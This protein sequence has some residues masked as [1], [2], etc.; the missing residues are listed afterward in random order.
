[1]PSA[2][3]SRSLARIAGLLA[4]GFLALLLLLA[5]LVDSDA[6][7]RRVTDV[8]LPRA[9]ALLGRTVTL[10][11]ARLSLFPLPAVEM[12][13]L[14]IEGLTPDRPLLSAGLAQ[15]RLAWWPLLRSFG[16][17]VEVSAVELDEVMLNTIR[18][19]DGS[20]AHDPVLARLNE[21]WAGDSSIAVTV[22]RF[23]LRDGVVRVLDRS[24]PGGVGQVALSD[25]DFT[26]TGLTP[27]D[28]ARLEW[29]AALQSAEQNVS[30]ELRIEPFPA[31][32]GELGPGEWPQVRGRLAVNGVPIESVDE[33]LPPAVA[34]TIS[35]G[36]VRLESRLRTDDDGR[37]ELHGEVDLSGL[38]LRGEPAEGR[39]TVSGGVEP[40]QWSSL[41][42]RLHDASVRGPGIALGGEARLRV[43]PVRVT[44]EV[45]GPLLDLDLLAGATPEPAEEAAPA[46]ADVPFLSPSTRRALQR[47]SV[48]GTLQVDRLVRGPLVANDLRAR[49][50]LREGE[51]RF[52]EAQAQF[53]GGGLDAAGTRLELADEVPKWNLAA[54]LETVDLGQAMQQVAGADPV[55]GLVSG[56]LA[57]SGRGVDW[58]QLRGGLDGTGRLRLADAGFPTA[59][60]S[61]QLTKALRTGLEGLAGRTLP[62]AP[63]DDDASAGGQDLEAWFKVDDG[64]LALQRPIGL[65]VGPGRLEL[66]GRIGLDQRL[67]LTGTLAVEPEFVARTTGG[68]FTPRGPVDVPVKIGGS[69]G[70]PKVESLDA[71]ALARGLVGHQQ[72]RVREK[73][74]E[75]ARERLEGF[76][77]EL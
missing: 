9:S 39:F 60:L 20:W 59:D 31:G 34:A 75:T 22:D 25:I 53:F 64:W 21:A 23:V 44:F 66:R 36:A 61:G 65:D 52:T 57:L 19:R 11:A 69:L 10:D 7:T 47:T 73:L 38:A 50:R 70:A 74:E 3:R 58:Q 63:D 1:M 54:R 26:A 42:L 46:P 35:G 55:R 49:A 68:R 41:E 32:F 6:V 51:L 15:A 12:R 17:E 8:A 4:A 77:R 24:A 13:G 56:G 43:A 37:Y 72:R 76:F 48:E 18:L 71:G 67:A 45:A 2:G 14:A 62:G 29:R 16:Q 5:A 40:G 33:F 28:T 27:G 30:G